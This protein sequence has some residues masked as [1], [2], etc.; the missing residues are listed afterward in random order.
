MC[1]CVSVC[2][3]VCLCARPHAGDGEGLL[4][5]GVAGEFSIYRHGYQPCG[6]WQGEFLHLIGWLVHVLLNVFVCVWY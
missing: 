6:G 3:S 5:D 4:E 1:V 2:V